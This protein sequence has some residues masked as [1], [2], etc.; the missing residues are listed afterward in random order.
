M[1]RELA[2]QLLEQGHDVSPAD[3]HGCLCGLL[4]A[5]GSPQGEAGL[6]GL[7]IAFITAGLLSLGFMGI[8]GIKI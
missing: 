1:P 2:N 5:G 4:A 6:Q 3:L 7:A 8:A